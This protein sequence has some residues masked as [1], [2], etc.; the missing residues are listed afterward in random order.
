M[1]QYADAMETSPFPRLFMLDFLS[2]EEKASLKAVAEPADKLAD[3]EVHQCP[4]AAAE[5]AEAAADTEVILIFQPLILMCEISNH[6]TFTTA[7]SLI[8]CALLCICIYIAMHSMADVVGQSG[9]VGWLV[10]RVVCIYHGKMAEWIKLLLG[11]R[12]D[13]VR[14][15]LDRPTNGGTLSHSKCIYTKHL[16]TGLYLW[17][18]LADRYI[19]TAQLSPNL[20]LFSHKMDVLGLALYGSLQ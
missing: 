6:F 7:F 18:H 10:G 9:L 14:W 12:V 5:A 19:C 15:G 20:F 4:L 8:I 1:I 17:Y 3:D 16:A 13:C 11:M 2:N